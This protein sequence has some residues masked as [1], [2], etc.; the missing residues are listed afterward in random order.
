MSPAKNQVLPTKKRFHIFRQKTKGFHQHVKGFANISI[1]ANRQNRTEPTQK[2]S[3]C[4][5]GMLPD[6]F[7]IFFAL[8]RFANTVFNQFSTQSPAK[9][10]G[11]ARLSTSVARQ[12]LSI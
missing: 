8:N 10:Y 12:F 9:A 2:L 11:L 7:F 1:G 6:M 5:K 3:R 4:S